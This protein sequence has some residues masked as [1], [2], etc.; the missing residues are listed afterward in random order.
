[1]VFA[2]PIILNCITA[3]TLLGCEGAMNQIIRTRDRATTIPIE[4]VLATLSRYARLSPGEC[5][6]LSIAARVPERHHAGSQLYLNRTQVKRTGLILCGWAC[7]TNILLDGRRQIYS[8]LLPGDPIFPQVGA[9]RASRSILALTDLQVAEIAAPAERDSSPPS[10]LMAAIAAA[11]AAREERLYTQITRLGRLSAYERVANLLLELR[12]RL[13]VGGMVSGNR[14]RM[15]LTQEI[16]ADALGLSL[17]HV[18][19]TLQQLRREKLIEMKAGSV[20]LLRPRA[21]ALIAGRE[22]DNEAMD[23]EDRPRRLHHFDAGA[24]RSASPG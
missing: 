22:D 17:V 4:T 10:G 19:R 13:S 2:K 6:K 1:L 7:E 11:A 12:D 9:G 24:Q 23:D 5:E 20:C 14:F 16:M 15:P 18:N 3:L 21:L 8:F